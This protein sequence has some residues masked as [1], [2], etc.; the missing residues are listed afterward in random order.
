MR[1]DVMRIARWLLI[2][3]AVSLLA[4]TAAETATASQAAPWLCRDKPVFSFSSPMTFRASNRGD[5]QW[6]LLLMRF[7]EG[8]EHGGFEIVT[9]R[10]VAPGAKDVDGRLSAGQYFAVAMYHRG[11]LWFCPPYAYET[12]PLS[13][14]TVSRIC[15]GDSR[16]DCRMKLTVSPA[17]AGSAAGTDKSGSES[18]GA[19][20]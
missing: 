16:S 7:R 3:S 13:A 5:R 14:R 15:Y 20:K 19:T 18:G 2:L 8:S 11:G 12:E 9:A 4:L 17:N 6:R 10:N 1:G